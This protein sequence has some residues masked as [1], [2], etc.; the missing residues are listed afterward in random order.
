MKQRILLLPN[1]HNWASFDS[2]FLDAA[3]IWDISKNEIIYVF[4]KTNINYKI[5]GLPMEFD[6]IHL[7]EAIVTWLDMHSFRYFDTFEFVKLSKRRA[8]MI[9]VILF[10]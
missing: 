5:T 3:S 6:K 9:H 8:K 2:S 10:R 1:D 7:K 4:E